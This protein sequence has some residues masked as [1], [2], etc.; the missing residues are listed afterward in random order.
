MEKNQSNLS[1]LE[2]IPEIAVEQS[3]DAEIVLPDY[4]PEITRVLKC[5][6]EVSF[7]NKQLNAKKIDIAGQVSMTLLYADKDDN[8][9]SYSYNVPFTKS[10]DSEF[11]YEN[12]FVSVDLR[13]EFLNTKATA[14]R[15]VE[16]HGSIN[17]GVGVTVY[18]TISI[19]CE[20]KEN[21]FSKPCDISFTEQFLPITKSLFLEDEISVGPN[22]Q[23]ISK[24]IRSVADVKINESKIISNKIVVKGEIK[25]Q[26]LYCP[27]Q[28]IRPILLEHNHAFSQIIDSDEVTEGC[29]CDAVG[30][31]VS[32]ELHPKTSLDGE[33]KSVTFE[34]KVNLDIQIEKDILSSCL[35][36]AYSN[37]YHS[38]IE[39]ASI[40]LIKRL[41]EIEENFVCKKSLEFSSGS[42]SEIYDV[43]SKNSLAYISC[44]DGEI[45]IK[46]TV[47]VYIIGCNTDGEPVYFER[48]VDY[49]YRYGLDDSNS[50][51]ICKPNVNI[52]AVNYSKNAENGVDIAVELIINTKI[53]TTCQINVVSCVSLDEESPITLDN[54]TAITLYFAE[55][56]KVWDIAKSY[57]A[58]P[59]K[60]CKVN[61]LENIDCICNKILLIPNM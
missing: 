18:K 42:I 30:K 2:K 19:P 40:N 41:N 23:S 1:T 33:V 31:V 58:D 49:E 9:N 34:A 11:D 12:G 25:I 44:D 39:F 55:G 22:K 35:T 13:G 60:I 27:T 4:Y 57:K 37:K 47:F 51:Y 32:L 53:Y 28:S 6:S 61:K 24:I 16:T 54:E 20:C 43:W 15:K 52:T 29:I 7:I 21:V 45:L 14:P 5:L 36:D 3:I 17:L 48:S 10:V 56:E 8:I 59:E 38:N 26:V 46:G 50:N